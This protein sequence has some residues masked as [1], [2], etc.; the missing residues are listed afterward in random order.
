MNSP[1]FKNRDG[2]LDFNINIH[3]KKHQDFRTHFVIDPKHDLPTLPHELHKFES[4][5]QLGSFIWQF[6]K[7]QSPQAMK[8]FKTLLVAEKIIPWITIILT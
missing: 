1:E 2:V 8:F 7:K 3:K 6:S 4:L 5:L